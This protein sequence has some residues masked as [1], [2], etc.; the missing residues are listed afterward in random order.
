MAFVLFR[1]SIIAAMPTPTITIARMMNSMSIIQSQSTS[2]IDKAVTQHNLYFAAYLFALALTAL[3]TWLVWKS[4]N[5]LQDEIR[6]DADARIEEAKTEAETARA[7]AAK[8]NERAVA[9]EA[10]NLILRR[11]LGTL[12][13]LVRE[14]RLLDWSALENV[15]RNGA[16]GSVAIL[17]TEASPDA[18]PIAIN[19]EVI[20][21][22][23]GWRVSRPKVGSGMSPTAGIMLELPEGWK[24]GSGNPPEPEL[25]EPAA[26]LYKAFKASGAG[27]GLRA[28][29]ALPKGALVIVIGTRF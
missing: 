11:E 19:L 16:S 22:R 28:N 17:Y 20:L 5:R 10:E 21:T 3:L 1:F 18:Y 27:I 14:G 29:E 2:A 13:N 12:G 6:A 7:E 23:N 4:G 26:T 24:S 15:L 8:A 25:P 9:L